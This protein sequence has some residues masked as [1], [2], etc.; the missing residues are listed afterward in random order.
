MTQTYPTTSGHGCD[1]PCLAF[2]SCLFQAGISTVTQLPPPPTTTTMLTTKM[3]QCKKCPEVF[4]ASEELLSH[5][6]KHLVL[7]NLVRRGCILTFCCVK[8]ASLSFCKIMVLFFKKEHF[9]GSISFY[10]EIS[11]PYGQ[12]LASMNDFTY[13]VL[14]G[15]SPILEPTTL[16]LSGPETVIWAFSSDQIWR[17]IS[18]LAAFLWPWQQKSRK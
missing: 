16:R 6:N 8:R 12:N 13:E 11:E 2:I 7:K 4:S 1:P 9:V 5:N 17:N 10:Y 18:D 14:L 15:G 3:F